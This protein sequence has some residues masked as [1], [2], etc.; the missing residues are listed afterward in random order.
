[1]A[2]AQLPSFPLTTQQPNWRPNFLS[3]SAFRPTHAGA[4]L[5]HSREAALHPRYWASPANERSALPLCLADAAAPRYVSSP[6]KAR[7]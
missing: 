6:P 1:L 3:P 5:L 4:Q 7:V 2:E